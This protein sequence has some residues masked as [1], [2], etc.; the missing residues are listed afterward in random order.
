MKAAPL[1]LALL[2]AAVGLAD[3]A[4]TRPSAPAPPAAGAQDLRPFIE[5]LRP[6]A[7]ARGIS[8]TTFAAAFADVTRADPDVLART[9]RQGEFARPVWEYLVGAVSPGRIARGQAQAA[10]LAT[11][12]AA[13]E[14][15]FGV[16]RWIVLAFWGV[17]SDF[18]ASAGTVPTIRALTTLAQAGFRG[19]LF[20]DELLA[21][22]TIL[23]RGDITP[24]AM[25]G[26][27]AGA[28][29]QVQ[30]LPSSFLAQ[31]VD[32]DG[33]GH[34][35]IWNSQ[36]DALASIANFLKSLGWNPA[37]SWGYAVTLPPNFD[38]TA[39]RADLSDFARR[40]VRR[41][42]GKPFPA[43]GNASLY[44]PGGLGGPSFLITDNFE[45]MRA[46]N[47]S[48]SYALAVGHLADRLA[49][50]PPLA[51]PWPNG[52]ARLDKAGLQALQT[53]LSARNLYGGEADGRAGPKLREA[54]RRYQIEQGLPADGYAT[55]A[56]LDHLRGRP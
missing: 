12:L 28:M 42:D 48:D 46:Y 45:V 30:F 21:A 37:V 1:G 7:L 23:E 40:G 53:G 2:L 47:T 26:S 54:V 19:P 27:W 32:F 6:E 33:D 22:L 17:E 34:R 20:R 15:R 25:K 55:P 16:P 24:G 36:A 38:L 29:G 10:R 13:I 41:T 9:R 35:D 4:P 14:A 51:A 50:G 3:A 11:T 5:A 44:L 31:A 56:L 18:G 49:G 52:T 43:S 39:Y 8:A